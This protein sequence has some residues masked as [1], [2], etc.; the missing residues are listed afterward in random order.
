MKKILGIFLSLVVILSFITVADTML[1]SRSASADGCDSVGGAPVIGCNTTIIGIPGGSGGSGGGTG[2]G[3]G[4]TGGGD[5]SGGSGGS[6]GE[7]LYRT[8]TNS[9][10]GGASCSIGSVGCLATPSRYL[11]S[12]TA[13]FYRPSATNSGWKV[14]SYSCAYAAPP[15]P[16]TILDTRI[17]F[18]NYDAVLYQSQNKD[19]I[20]SGGSL[21]KG[22]SLP[23]PRN[24][25]Y[26]GP[27][28]YYG[29]VQNVGV[30]QYF[31]LNTPENGGNQYYRYGLSPRYV[32]CSFIGYPRWT[33]DS[34]RD[35]TEC[36]GVRN[37]GTINTYA[38][39]ACAFNYAKFPSWE[40]LPPSV[41]FSIGGCSYY[42]CVVD[43]PT[44]VN[45]IT[46]PIEV[47]RSG[48]NIN[49][50]LSTIHLDHDGTVRNVNNIQGKLDVVAGST[51]MNGELNNAKQYFKLKNAKTGAQQSWNVWE[52][53]D[54][55]DKWLNFFWA[56]DTGK[57]FTTERTY[58]F[59]A[60]FYVLVASNT[61]GGSSYMWQKETRTFP[62]AACNS[63][64]G[65]ISV[66][67][68]VNT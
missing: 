16:N 55:T 37:Y 62:T 26:L 6:G 41:D 47:M 50:K 12:I 1:N 7:I 45:G 4:G 56:G 44:T 65:P 9:C 57:P 38:V 27:A 46:G 19:A 66:L 58:R 34:S 52:A 22:A 8:L 18:V 33:Q 39:N 23:N 21:S 61:G 28:S 13:V 29:C 54:Q 32:Q 42:R 11:V 40:S 60:E 64:S 17:C 20:R 10:L 63:R 25:L 3:G 35:R 14:Y 67:R 53:Q 48:E 59:S 15:N 5:G 24:N 51:P 49:L 2:G 30:G 31:N 43:A 36:S 68:S